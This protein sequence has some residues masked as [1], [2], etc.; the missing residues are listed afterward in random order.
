MKSSISSTVA[1]SVTVAVIFF[2]FLSTP[3][4]A[5]GSGSTYAVVYGSDTVCAVISGQPTQ[6]ILCH[7]T[8]LRTNLTLNPGVSF[9]SIAAGENF[10][11][12]IR[13]GGYSLLC[14]FNLIG[15]SYTL[16]PKRIYHNDTVLLQSLSV[17][18]TQI[19]AVVNGT[20]A[21]KCWRND[22]S[23][24]P[25][26]GLVTVSSGV[27][28]SCGVSVRNNRVLCWGKDPVKS[29]QI[30]TGFGNQTMV[31]VSAGE[32]HACGLNSTGGLICT[33]R[34]ESGQLN[35][36]SGQPYLFSDLSLG[37]NFTCAIRT[38]NGSVTCWGGGAERFN[39]V[40]ENISFESVTSGS[41][42]ICGLISGNLSVMCWSPNNFSRI[43]LPFQ[44]ILPG[45]CVEPSICK[46]G[47]YPRSDQLC[48]G[49]GSICSKCRILPPPQ[50]SPPPS[51]PSTPSKGLTRGLLA[52]AIVGSVGAFAGVCSV[53]Y[54]LWTGGFLGKK[55]VHNSVQPTITRG[56][57]STRSSSSPPSRSLT[58]RRQ[59]SRMFSMRR[60]RSGTSSMKHTDKAE[61]FS[62]SELASATGNFS[63]E[64][65][66]GSGSFGVV[67]RGKLNDGREVAIKRGDVNAKMK[68]F[69]EKETAFDSEIAFL[70]RL[71]HKH[72]VRLVG[73]CEERDEKLLVYDYMK[74]GALH[75]HLHDRNNVE[76]H[77]SLVN[78][79]KMRIKIALDAARG[80]EYLHIY[81][82]PP[83]IHRDIK[84]S[85]ILLDSN[86]VARV[87]DFG[88]SLMGPEL[89][90]D[91]QQRP[92][93]A[94]GTVGYI[95]PEY[96]SLNV[97]TDK[98][99]V[100]GL[101]VVLLELLTGKRAIFRNGGDVEEECAPVH[102]VEYAV[103]AIEMG[104]LGRVLDPRV[105]LPELG[106]GD[107]VELV[108][109]T[110]MHCVNAEGRNRP[111]M[112]DIV[113]NLER[114]LELCGDSHGSISSG[115]CSIVSD[116]ERD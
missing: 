52:F 109:N 69:Q 99:D 88:L 47:V 93:K 59:G 49:S 76:K 107:A 96:Y 79:W 39:N 53:V 100:Y 5:L 60:Q 34:N 45:P 18:N 17:G 74:N 31:S 38:T 12:G 41:G 78:S 28:F 24:A 115:I 21:V 33:G 66:V 85:N 23:K 101:G 112:T 86:W 40:T 89:G 63:L 27:G 42:L 91:H 1:F 32:S 98:S 103:S 29:G 64:N 72:L 30:Q 6:R 77:S 11:C 68:K 4:S 26:E 16:K 50:P 110:A 36:P 80:I 9:S 73:Y 35:A 84:S 83:I 8:R 57:S 46:C 95:D 114:A 116:I 22:P 13:S 3:S 25:N 97:L 82:V 65:K 43:F 19:C 14:W 70:S 48:S 105:G 87:S 2:S 113:G 92:M 55:K 61:A 20:N 7:N 104:E 108:G 81:A 58:F 51:P 102:L 15:S 44:D 106:E 111:T 75:D 90:K 71:H 67:Y 94:A 56:G 10:L 62:F 54:C 37:S